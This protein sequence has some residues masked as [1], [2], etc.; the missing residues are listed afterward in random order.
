[1]TI[2]FDPSLYIGYF[3]IKV[4]ER[5]IDKERKKENHCAKRLRTIK[6]SKLMAR[7]LFTLF[8]L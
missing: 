5:V 3:S 8:S 1:M 2:F 4:V 6:I 7:S